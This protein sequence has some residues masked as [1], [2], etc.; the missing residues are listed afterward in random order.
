MNLQH[1]K[2][3]GPES[4]LAFNGW[5]KAMLGLIAKA[6][7]GVWLCPDATLVAAPIP[8]GPMGPGSMTPERTAH[9]DLAS[10]R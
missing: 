9:G 1:Q 4:D 8:A 3:H 6:Q 5:L 7:A 10:R 2:G